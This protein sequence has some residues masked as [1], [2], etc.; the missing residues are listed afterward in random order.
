MKKYTV[1]I[2]QDPTNGVYFITVEEHIG[3]VASGIGEV[4]GKVEGRIKQI[5]DLLKSQGYKLK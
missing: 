3:L 2:H 4:L 5:E 1:H